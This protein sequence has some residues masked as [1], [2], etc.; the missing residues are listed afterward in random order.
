LHT[1]DLKH[2]PWSPLRTSLSHI[3]KTQE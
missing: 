1:H 2:L 3:G